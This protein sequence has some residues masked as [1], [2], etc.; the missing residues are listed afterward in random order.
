MNNR[1]KY[2]L[3]GLLRCR[4][5]SKYCLLVTGFSMYTKLPNV[6]G[7]NYFEK[8]TGYEERFTITVKVRV[9]GWLEKLRSGESYLF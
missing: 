2:W 6:Y 3:G 5:E 1:I 9:E 8:L 4:L 7:R